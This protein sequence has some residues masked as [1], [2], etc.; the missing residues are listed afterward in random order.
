[1][2]NEPQFN[3]ELR[4]LCAARKVTHKVTSLTWLPNGDPLYTMIFV[5]NY[6]DC[7]TA[8]DLVN[9][10][11]KDDF[12]VEPLEWHEFKSLFDNTVVSFNLIAFAKIITALTF[13]KSE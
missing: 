1:M 8:C 10:F 7:D 3:P 13:T 9:S 4:T 12:E 5:G 6:K 2:N 11:Y